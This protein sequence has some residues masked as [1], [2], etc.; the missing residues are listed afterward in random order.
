MTQVFTTLHEELLPVEDGALVVRSGEPDAASPKG[1]KGGRKLGGGGKVGAGSRYRMAMCN[2]ERDVLVKGRH[3]VEFELV[4]AAGNMTI[5]V[6]QTDYDPLKVYLPGEQRGAAGESWGMSTR[7]GSLSFRGKV[8]DWPGRRPAAQGD[9]IGMLVDLKVGSLTVFVNS[10]P[11]GKMV[12][13]GLTG[14]LCW[15]TE[16]S[17]AA[18]SVRITRL[19]PL[20]PWAR[21]VK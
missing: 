17:T 2:D 6:A 12:A 1:L 8:S 19:D 18:D 16:L 13:Q 7:S 15:M 11:A 14:P 9:K 20:P 5:G 21:A 10:V 4:Q 3:L